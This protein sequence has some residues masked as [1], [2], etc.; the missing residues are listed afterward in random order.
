[1]VPET[2]VYAHCLTRDLK[3]DL[4]RPARDATVWPV[5]V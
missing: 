2:V 1:M 3:I 5:V 4:Y